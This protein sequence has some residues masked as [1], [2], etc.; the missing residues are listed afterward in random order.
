MTILRLVLLAVVIALGTVLAGWWIVPV[1]GAGYGVLSKSTRFPGFTA[2]AAGALAWGG[3][4]SALALGGAPVGA[5][6]A[7]VAL[8]MGVPAP[9]PALA[10]LL[11]P[12]LLAGLAAYAAARL[13]DS[14]ESRRRAG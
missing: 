10:T 1:I 14:P 7:R 5:F 13:R 2:A 4:L 11:L 12:A 9:V 6:S 3:Y 8:S